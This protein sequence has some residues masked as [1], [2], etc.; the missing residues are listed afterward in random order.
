MVTQKGPWV[1]GWVNTGHLATGA[2]AASG[3]Q[4]KGRTPHGIGKGQ[5]LVLLKTLTVFME[6]MGKIVGD[7][8][9]WNKTQKST[10]RSL[11]CFPRLVSE[12]QRLHGDLKWFGHSLPQFGPRVS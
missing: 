9:Y 5:F 7:W 8:R 4:K 2:Q 1:C 6:A 11:Y 10:V 12:K 3:E